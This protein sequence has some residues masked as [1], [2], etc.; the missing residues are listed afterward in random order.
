M[1]KRLIQMNW[2]WLHFLAFFLILSCQTTV[3]PGTKDH[4]AYTIKVTPETGRISI[5]TQKAS[6]FT[7]IRELKEKHQIEVII[8]NLSDDRV[9]TVDISDKPIHEGLAMLIPEDL[10]YRFRT[11]DI[12]TVI[13]GTTGGKKAPVVS[14]PKPGNLPTKDKT[15]PLGPQ[16]KRIVKSKADASLTEKYSE[17]TSGTKTHPSRSIGIET[18]E[19]KIPKERK[20]EGYR[21]ARLN[22]FIDAENNI[23]VEQLMEIEGRLLE[24]RTYNGNFLYAAYLGNKIISVGSM[25]DPL[26]VRSLGEQ[27]GRLTTRAKQGYFSI[28]LPED[29]LKKDKITIGRVDFYLIEDDA[30]MPDEI[31][32]RTFEKIAKGLVTISRIGSKELLNSFSKIKRKGE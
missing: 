11:K 23:R 26:L 22:L 29:F 12:E 17:G 9:V 18:K 25:Q 13:P 6:L 21:Y 15:K 24:S 30:G 31:T 27:P 4:S 8:P 7:I 10:K 19:R 16:K 28:S 1:K 2:P 5:K 3:P 32:P 14:K 20:P